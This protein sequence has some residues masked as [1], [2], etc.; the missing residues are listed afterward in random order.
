[1]DS[2]LTLLAVAFQVRLRS[3]EKLERS[4]TR[5]ES[6]LV[7]LVNRLDT[8]KVLLAADNA[9]LVLHEILGRQAAGR[10]LGRAVVD[11]RLAARRHLCRLRRLASVLTTE[12]FLI[13]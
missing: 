1:L 4:L 12:H 8:Q 10:V 11:L 5:L 6:R 13:R 2:Q 7:K 9:P 3:L